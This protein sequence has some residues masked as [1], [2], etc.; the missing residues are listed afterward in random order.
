MRLS[1]PAACGFAMMATSIVVHVH[2]NSP[3]TPAEKAAGWTSLFD[4]TTTDGWRGY[5]QKSFPEKGW[6]IED[7]CLKVEAKGGGGDLVTANQYGDF[8][9]SL[10]WKAA[11]AANSGIIY[12]VT[13]QHD[14]SWQSG[15]EFQVLDDAGTKTENTSVHSAGSLYDIAA[16][17]AA[18]TLKPAGEFNHARIRLHHGLLTHW[19][20]GVKVV[21][22]R[23][24]NDEWKQK[25]A[26]SKFK[27]ADGFG[28][29]PRGHIALQDH[30]DTVWYR[31]IRIID[32]DAP[33][34]GE[35]KLLDG[36]SL[37]GWTA[38]LDGDATMDDVW[39]VED[40]VM[41]CKGEPA[42]YIRTEKDYEN[43]VLRVQWRFSPVTRQPGN[44]GVLVR[45]V[46]P[47]VIW[48]KSVEAQLHHQNAGD[49]WC[50]GD[51]PMKTPPERTNGRNTKKLALA[52][53]PVG[54]W[55]DYEITVDRGTI[56]LRIN[57]ELVNQATEVEQVP[58]KIGLQSEGAEIH[59]RDIRLAPIQ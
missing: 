4:G 44:S 7:G 11:P 20:N 57:G 46:G 6:S 18:K 42:G 32:L 17:A 53:Q 55:N 37:A 40:G 21:E 28:L 38:H 49:F 15:P 48:P 14:N 2:A 22:V 36:E 52:E 45:M 24:D 13:E 47:D 41:I 8:E 35:V 1:L 50:I 58:G 31:D 33:M 26:G 39:R 51:F 30:G 10:E 3:L 16:P 54:E 19:L 43:Y 29:Q 12:R 56:T 27:S 25:I 5:K 34:P 9:L 59:F 23:V